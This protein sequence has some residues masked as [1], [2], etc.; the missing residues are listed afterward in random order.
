A[1]LVSALLTEGTPTRSASQIAETIDS[2]GGL[3]DTGAGWD[4]SYLSLSVLNDHEALAF[5]LLS[6]M[7]M[8]SSFAPAE[9]ERKRRQTISG[10]EV[11]HD[12]ADYVADA[13]LRRLAFL[14][15]SYGHPEDG[16][17]A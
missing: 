9:F 16:T 13:A 1:Q 10:L 4:E 2:I 12:D 7:A 5:D 11:V 15:T 8:H 3:V 17:L 14:G 6:D